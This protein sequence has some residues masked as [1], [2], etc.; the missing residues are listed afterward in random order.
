LRDWSS[1]N[2]RGNPDGS[3]GIV[4]TILSLNVSLYGYCINGPKRLYAKVVTVFDGK[5]TDS[6]NIWKPSQYTAYRL[7]LENPSLYCP[8][9]CDI[10][11]I[12]LFI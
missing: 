3:S 5:V 7:A 2:I 12:L 1:E 4:N 6:A 10:D 9:N 11:A 8:L